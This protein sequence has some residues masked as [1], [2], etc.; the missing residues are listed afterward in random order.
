MPN[1]GPGGI[2][3]AGRFICDGREL[4]YSYASP[5]PKDGG[6][7]DGRWNCGAGGRG[8]AGVY[9]VAVLVRKFHRHSSQ[10]GAPP[11]RGV[12]HCGHSSGAASGAGRPP[13]WL[14]FGPPDG[15]GPPGGGG[16]P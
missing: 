16:K 3:S 13:G 1:G 8:A 15:P 5:L 11:S 9:E 6:G 14:A 10:N 7:P 4:W 12:R 2:G